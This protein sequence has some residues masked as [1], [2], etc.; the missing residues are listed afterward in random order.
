M[1][2]YTSNETYQT[3]KEY[4]LKV[5]KKEKI[6]LNSS[7]EKLNV[8]DQQLEK[9]LAVTYRFF[10]PFFA[11]DDV[12]KTYKNEYSEKTIDEEFDAK[13]QRQIP[14]WLQ[15]IIDFL[16]S[17]YRLLFPNKLLL[18]LVNRIKGFIVSHRFHTFSILKILTNFFTLKSSS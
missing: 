2:N 13:I 17:I 10:S 5:L 8:F 11:V 14:S 18:S 12:P 6:N 15:V 3:S 1:K 4:Y 16:V 7:K 9:L